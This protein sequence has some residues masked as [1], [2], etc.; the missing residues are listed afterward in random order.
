MTFDEAHQIFHKAYWRYTHWTRDKR[1]RYALQET[2]TRMKEEA[3]SMQ[4]P[5]KIFDEVLGRKLIRSPR[6]YTYNT[7]V[8]IVKG[9]PD[10]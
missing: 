7:P 5:T 9:T 6:P 4:D 3:Q 2:L 8:V 10:Q 1:T